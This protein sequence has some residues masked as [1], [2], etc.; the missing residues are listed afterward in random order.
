MTVNNIDANTSPFYGYDGQAYEALNINR[1]SPLELDI[2]YGGPYRHQRKPRR[3]RR[4]WVL[5]SLIRVI[6]PRRVPVI[7]A[8]NP[9]VIS[10]V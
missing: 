9:S 10:R 3:R 4:Y 2:D 5:G 7:P 1:L 6:K 8:L